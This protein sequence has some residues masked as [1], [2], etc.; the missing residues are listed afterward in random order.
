M[1]V[2]LKPKALLA[3]QLF[4]GRLVAV[5]IISAVIY[6]LVISYRNE[7]LNSVRKREAARN[8][9]NATIIV[10]TP[11]HRRKERIGDMLRGFGPSTNKYSMSSECADIH[12]YTTDSSTNG[13]YM[14][15]I[16][17]TVIEYRPA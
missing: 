13:I 15:L 8:A 11:T 9:R 2:R 4:C 12:L 3:I 10:V 6:T 5:V 16:A 1:L 14:A 7:F 17:Q